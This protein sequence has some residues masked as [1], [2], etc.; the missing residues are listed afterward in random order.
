MGIFDAIASTVNTGLNMWGARNQQ[1]DSM[2]QTSSAMQYNRENMFH[3]NQVNHDEA[4]LLRDWQASQAGEARTWEA[5]QAGIA[6]DWNASMFNQ[7]R[8][9]N[10]EQAQINRD[11][12]ERMSNSQ[13]QRATKDMMAAGINPMLAISQGG[14]GNLSGSGA[15]ASAPS[16]S[17]PSTSIPGGAKGGAGGMAG[18]PPSTQFQNVI[19]AGLSSA[20]ETYRT[21]VQARQVEAMT[22][23]QRAQ[24]LN[25]LAD[26]QQKA[27]STELT[28]AQR[29]DLLNKIK[30]FDYGWNE[31]YRQQNIRNEAQIQAYKTAGDQFYPALKGEEWKQAHKKSQFMDLEMAGRMSESEF[32]E[33]LNDAVRG[34]AN[35]AGFLGAILRG[36]A[37]MRNLWR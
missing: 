18:S 29:A 4:V 7:E 22:D 37:G 20:L 12:Q 16:T 23:T 34:G 13:Y 36:A 31:G 9:F 8:Q 15:S 11:F 35:S 24:T 19:G 26:T 33:M 6:R 3:Q 14:A 5:G 32:N 25:V 2:E 1:R 28:S 10:A 27:A 17:A 21:L 30:E